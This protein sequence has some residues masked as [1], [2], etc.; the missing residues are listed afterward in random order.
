MKFMLPIVALCLFSG[1]AYAQP[2]SGFYEI[3]EI[4]SAKVT[5]QMGISNQNPL[6]NDL[7]WDWKPD[8]NGSDEYGTLR[9]ISNE[10]YEMVGCSYGAKLKLISGVWKVLNSSGVATHTI[11]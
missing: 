8:G 7:N 9:W 3:T 4:S 5:G 11:G 6:V 1:I 2:A 10:E